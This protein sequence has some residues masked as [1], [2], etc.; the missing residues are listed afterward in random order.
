MFRINVLQARYRRNG[1]RWTDGERVCVRAYLDEESKTGPK[2]S[3]A[4]VAREAQ[5]ATLMA[6]WNA[7]TDDVVHAALAAA[8]TVA[9]FPVPVS[10]VPADDPVSSAETDE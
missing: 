6:L 7:T 9:G 10:A 2:K 4:E 5:H 8:F 3:H 1:K